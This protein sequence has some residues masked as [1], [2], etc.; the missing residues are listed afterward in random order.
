MNSQ[1]TI[2]VEFYF[3][4]EKH[5]P[6]I[7]VNLDQFLTQYDDFSS[8]Y[9]QLANQNGIGHYSYEYEVM[10]STPLVFFNAQ[11][12]AAD[13]LND[14]MFDLPGFKLALENERVGRVLD[15]LADQHLPTTLQSSNPEIK[16]AL[17]AAYRLG[18]QNTV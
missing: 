7:E 14:G 17:M 4:G 5:T 16:A 3:K 10:E 6:S 13:F 18:Q 1:I 2:Q 15:E 11:G 12:L 9:V 8:I